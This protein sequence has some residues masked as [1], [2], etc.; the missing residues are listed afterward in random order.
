MNQYLTA[1][2]APWATE[3][4]TK[5]YGKVNKT[6]LRKSFTDFPATEMVA[7]PGPGQRGGYFTMSE[8]TDTIVELRFNDD[9]SVAMVSIANGKVTVA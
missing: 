5:T 1:R 7:V 8:V 6:T 2:L 4:I 3:R 9:R